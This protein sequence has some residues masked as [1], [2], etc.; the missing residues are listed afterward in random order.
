MSIGVSIETWGVSL[1][2]RQPCW[3]SLLGK[4]GVGGNYLWCIVLVIFMEF[5]RAKRLGG[6]RG[7][8]NIIWGRV[9]YKGGDQ[10]SWGELTPLHTMGPSNYYSVFNIFIMAKNK[11]TKSSKNRINWSQSV[12][13]HTK[14]LFPWHHFHNILSKKHHKISIKQRFMWYFICRV[15]LHT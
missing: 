11:L 15:W 13:Y 14:E 1:T 2:W 4:L 9:S 3:R 12:T 10:F 7:F 8:K 5:A 6:R